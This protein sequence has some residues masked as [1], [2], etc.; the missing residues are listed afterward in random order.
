MCYYFWGVQRCDTITLEAMGLSWRF[1]DL[2]PKTFFADVASG[3]AAIVA[4][5]AVEEQGIGE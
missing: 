3:F 4:R 2:L 5:Q 1:R